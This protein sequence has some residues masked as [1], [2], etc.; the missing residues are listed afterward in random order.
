MVVPR[1]DSVFLSAQNAIANTS[2]V[3]WKLAKCAFT[4]PACCSSRHHKCE[5]ADLGTMFKGLMPQ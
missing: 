1:D 2:F 4:T 5:A 3:A